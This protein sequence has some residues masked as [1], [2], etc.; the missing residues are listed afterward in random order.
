MN[1]ARLLQTIITQLSNDLAVLM[2]A[3]KSSHDA[4]THAENIPDN[5]YDTLAL[6]A[7]YVAQGQANR[8]RQIRRSIELYRQLNRLDQIDDTIQLGSLITM[9]AASG[10]R[11]SL[12]IGV[13]EGGLRIMSDRGE[14]VVITVS[15][16]IGRELLG[17]SIGDSVAIGAGTAHLEYEI[18]EVS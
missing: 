1:K 14:I 5:K 10:A 17:K 13:A 7:S 12:F 16:P 9:E 8:A 6:E 15:S 2:T 11:K 18:I 3:A 4:A